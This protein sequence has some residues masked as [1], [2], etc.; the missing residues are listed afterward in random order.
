MG[1][2]VPFCKAAGN[3]MVLLTD[4]VSPGRADSHLLEEGAIRG[5]VHTA[6]SCGDPTSG[7]QETVIGCA[8]CQSLH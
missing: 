5:N 1:V 8:S 4:L 6:Y 3:R 2:T 7:V